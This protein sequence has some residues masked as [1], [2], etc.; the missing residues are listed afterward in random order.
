MRHA[1][2]ALLPSSASKMMLV[3]AVI[4]LVVVGT[5]ATELEE[6]AEQLAGK[7]EGKVN[8]C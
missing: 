5:R 6:E 8:Y 7:N 2:A 1:P 3:G 4:A